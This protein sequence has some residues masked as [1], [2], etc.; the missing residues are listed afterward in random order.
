MFDFN[1]PYTCVHCGSE[2]RGLPWWD[3]CSSCSDLIDHM[4]AERMATARA[5]RAYTIVSLGGACPTQ[6]EGLTADGRPYYFRARHGD[7]TLEVGEVGWPVD[8]GKWPHDRQN[9]RQHEVAS[10]DDPS[11]GWMEDSDV[12]AILDEHLKESA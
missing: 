4:N 9:W 5:G 11:N 3:T 10:G 6:A 2:E 1:Q 12:L 7:W 8:Y